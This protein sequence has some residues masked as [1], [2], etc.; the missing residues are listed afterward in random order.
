MVMFLAL[1]VP[2]AIL[3]VAE[4]FLARTES[5]W[6]GRVLPI[7]LFRADG[8]D[9]PAQHGAPRLVG[10]SGPG[11]FGGAGAPEPPHR[12][13]CGG[14]P[15]HPAALC[16]TAQ[17]GA[18]GH[19]GPVVLHQAGNLH[20][21]FGGISA[22]LRDRPWWASA[23]RRPLPCSAKIPLEIQIC[24]FRACLKIG[25]VSSREGFWAAGKQFFAGILA[26]F[27]EKLRRPGGKRPAGWAC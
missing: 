13:L 24:K 19:P 5:P 3:A 23:H 6:P 7:L 26:D 17:H 12:R 21:P 8:P 18:P 2:T 20:L 1:L 10:H 15:D 16:R 11:G 22:S 9:G 27:K 25:D 14:L 4:Y